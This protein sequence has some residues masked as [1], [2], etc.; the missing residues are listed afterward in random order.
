[1]TLQVVLFQTAKFLLAEKKKEKKKI[2][3]NNIENII[4]YAQCIKNLEKYNIET[5][6]HLEHN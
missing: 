4:P 1:V 5:K 2:S 6:D 3:W